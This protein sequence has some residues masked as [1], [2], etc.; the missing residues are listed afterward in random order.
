[1]LGSTIGDLRVVPRLRR[2]G[3]GLLIVQDLVRRGGRSACCVNEA[4][5]SLFA[6]A[7][8]VTGDGSWYTW[9]G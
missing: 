2:R 7:G 6:R 3:Y 5:Q 8:F 4:S 1:M 9:P